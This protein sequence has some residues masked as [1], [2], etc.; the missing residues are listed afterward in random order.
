[1]VGT[2][3]Y[4]ALFVRLLSVETMDGF[5]GLF[6]FFLLRILLRSE[7]AAAAALV[8]ALSVPDLLQVPLANLTLSLVAMGVI[9][10]ALVIFLLWRVGLVAMI[11]ALF[12]YQVFARY[13]MTFQ[14]SWWYSGLG[15]TALLIVG[16]IA[17]YGFKT[18]LGGRP[19]V[20]GVGLDD[21]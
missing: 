21:A 5:M 2:G 9:F 19:F 1:M 7:W 10:Y 18:S 14:A 11:A 16:A 12:V 8:V 4:V 6:L 17:L 15:Y 20:A 13:P 3:S